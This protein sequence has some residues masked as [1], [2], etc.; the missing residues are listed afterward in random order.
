EMAGEKDCSMCHGSRLEAE[1]SAVRLRDLTLPQLCRMPL[2]EAIVFL[3]NL[4]LSKSEKRIAGDLLN[5]ATHRLNFLTE[6][7]LEYLT[8]DRS[9][10]TLSGGESQ[11]IRLAGQAG[12]SL[13]GVLY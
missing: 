8:L 5:E 4:K 6:V 7:G 1:A 10:P 11:R 9:M 2:S 13:T 12:R 3:K